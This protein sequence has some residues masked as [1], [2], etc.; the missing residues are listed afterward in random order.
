MINQL[1]QGVAR[2]R[3]LFVLMLSM[4]PLVASAWSD[5][6]HRLTCDLAFDQLKPE[7]QITIREWMQAMPAE[8]AQTFLSKSQPEV[9][10]LCVWADKVR[11]DKAFDRVASWHYVNVDRD[12]RGVNREACITGCI[13]TAIDTHL[14]L[15]QETELSLWPKLQALM[16]LMHWVG[17]LH[18]PM[19]VSFADDLGGNRAKVSGYEDCNNMH[20]VWD[21]CL[22][23][24]TG[25][26]YASLLQTLKR[27]QSESYPRLPLDPEVWADESFAIARHPRT[28]YCRQDGSQC[29]PWAS[30]QYQLTEDYQ[31]MNWPIAAA[32]IQQ[33]GARLAALLNHALVRAQ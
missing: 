2:F 12:A 10:D 31:Q 21:Y 11:K 17:D 14:A 4:L 20:G 9:N 18:Q 29:V 15:I 8:H 27:A 3:C 16:F 32:R 23:K 30:R 1:H 7:A 13:L 26:D 22:V 24:E 33:A 25:E 6:G 5:T 19:H 28:Q